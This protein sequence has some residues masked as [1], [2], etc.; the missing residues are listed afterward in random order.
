MYQTCRICGCTDLRACVSETGPCHWVEPDL[1]SACVGNPSERKTKIKI[2]KH[3]QKRKDKLVKAL[4]KAQE[5]AGIC[6]LYVTANDR[7]PDQVAEIALAM[8]HIEMALNHLGAPIE[9]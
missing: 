8:N 2:N 4:Q 1:C 3:D 6:W 5:M 9:R 7:P